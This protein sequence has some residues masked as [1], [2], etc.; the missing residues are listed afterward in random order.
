VSVQQA[1]DRLETVDLI[2]TV[3]DVLDLYAIEGRRAGIVT[4][5]DDRLGPGGGRW[6]G[7]PG[8]LGQVILNLLTNAE[9]YAYGPGGGPVDVVVASDS[10]PN[11]T[12]FKVTIADHGAGIPEADRSRIFEPFFTT[13]RGRGGSGL[14]LAIVHNLV[15]A[16]M[17]GAI[18]LESEVGAGTAVTVTLPNLQEAPLS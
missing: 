14:G 2:E 16:G 3:R 15:T 4:T 6:T 11:A 7:Y 18:T 10:S 9:R 1:A 17:G 12:V 5:L 8:H 13:G